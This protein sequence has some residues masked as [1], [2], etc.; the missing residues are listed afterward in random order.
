M[1]DV[2]Q[3]LIELQSVDD[4]VREFK[5]Q[6]DE[7]STNL[8]TLKTILSGMS[9]ELEDKREKLAE[10]DR[11][12]TDQQEELR[13]DGERMSRAKQKLAAVTRTKEYA[14]VQRELDNIRKKYG[15]D[16]AELKRLGE[17]MEEYKVSIAAQEAKLAE[18]QGEVSKE[19]AANVDRLGSLTAQ[20]DGVDGRRGTISGRLDD[21]TMRRYE[22]VLSRREGRAVV[23]A[24]NGKCTGCQMKLPPQLFILVQR[25][26][27]LQSCPACQRFLFFKAPEEEDAA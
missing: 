13:A 6:R 19:E 20:I 23:A 8:N 4:E 7:L 5:T 3:A 26:E 25:L 9:T 10:A 2:I 11:F 24:L 17:A 22:R 27:T 15:E 1:R 14:A 18:L 21:R 12:Y 16:E